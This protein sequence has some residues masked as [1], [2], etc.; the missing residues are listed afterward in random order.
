M[1]NS[2]H[3]TFFH[4]IMASKIL[5]KRKSVTLIL[6]TDTQLKNWSG[7]FDYRDYI[8]DQMS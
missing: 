5:S 6:S 8:C 2:G 1:L 7:A 3:Y 4:P